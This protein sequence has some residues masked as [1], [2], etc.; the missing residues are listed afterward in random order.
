MNLLGSHPW[1]RASGV[2]KR[3]TGRTC[4]CVLCFSDPAWSVSTH[5]MRIDPRRPVPMNNLPS[6]RDHNLMGAM[7]GVTSWTK[8]LML[9]TAFDTPFWPSPKGW[10]VPKVE[11]TP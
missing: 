2:T 8:I 10:V 5:R 11:L 4:M 9:M 7:H 3:N 6:N 1:R